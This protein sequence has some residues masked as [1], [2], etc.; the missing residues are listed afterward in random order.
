MR[1]VTRIPGPHR[2]I[3]LRET[4]PERGRASRRDRM[5]FGAKAAVAV[6]A[7]VI[8]T[9]LASGCE[10][11]VGGTSGTRSL[12]IS[13]AAAD[14]EVSANGQAAVTPV[15]YLFNGIGPQGGSFSLQ[16][17]DGTASLQDLAVGSWTIQVDALNDDGIVVYN[18][19]TEAEVE[20]SGSVQIELELT[21]VTG[22]GNLQVSAVWD[23]R[24][25]ISPTATVILTDVG[26]NAQTFELVV[27]STGSA[28]RIIENLPTGY[29][30]IALRLHDSGEQVMGNATT[31]RVYNGLTLPVATELSDLN[32][33]GE[34][35]EVR[36]E[37][38]TIAWDAP[39]DRSP[40]DYRVY[41]RHRGEGSWTL[42]RQ[43]AAEVAPTFT[44]DREDLPYGNYE[45][46][47][48]A[49][50]SGVE[51]ALHTSMC[52]E[53]QPATGWY[54]DWVGP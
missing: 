40:S 52:D 46:A 6:M 23:G 17:A 35:V 42:L 39:V 26:G 2:T 33:V 53:A 48:S 30:R 44:I 34:A 29:Y 15:S 27:D 16:S 7:V 14:S 12:S 49:L 24:L 32:K 51:S 22:H 43:I 38:F 31:T 20:P 5:S 37:R 50:V 28:S 11:V 4:V 9:V 36:S 21:P 54:I 3:A 18:A 1:S 25:T 10:Q 13:V 45:L 41:A 8:L 47:V 19:E